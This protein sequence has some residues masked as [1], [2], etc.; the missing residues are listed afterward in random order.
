M[1]GSWSRTGA[2]WERDCSEGAR[3]KTMLTST[4]LN[5]PV[6]AVTTAS[7]TV[8]DLTIK[9]KEQGESAPDTSG[10]SLI[11]VMVKGE[12]ATLAL[13]NVE[14]VSGKAG[15]GG[16]A[17]EAKP[18]GV[19]MCDGLTD[20]KSGKE[21]MDGADGGNADQ[22]TFTSDGYSPGNGKKGT[23]GTSG[24]NGS[25]GGT[26]SNGLVFDAPGSMLLSVQMVWKLMSSPQKMGVVGAL[27]WLVRWARSEWGVARLSLYLYPIRATYRYRW[28]M[29]G[30]AMEGQGLPG[31][32]A[33]RLCQV[34]MGSKV[35]KAN[36]A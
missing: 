28:E 21:G 26:F 34:Q 20:C 8:S 7:V 33:P 32:W 30:L 17:S 12:G 23:Q 10:E 36:H 5:T 18:G 2:V 15:D 29:S 14:V 11:G 3:G 4:A 13:T 35:K 16:K 25:S 19:A 27:D 22:G 1:Q 9:T 31:R 24:E 6:V